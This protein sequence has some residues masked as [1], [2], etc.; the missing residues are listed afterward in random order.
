MRDDVTS[1]LVNL[2]Y[3]KKEAE[4]AVS[5]AETDLAPGP[6]VEELLKAALS[7]LAR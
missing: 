4:S 2:G 7:R 6:D 5:H 1:A 3:R